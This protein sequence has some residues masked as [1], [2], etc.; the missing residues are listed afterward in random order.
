MVRSGIYRMVKIYRMGVL[1]SVISVPRFP[2]AVPEDQV[3]QV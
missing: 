1:P 2:L 3:S